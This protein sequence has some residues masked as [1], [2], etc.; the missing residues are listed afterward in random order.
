[1]ALIFVAM[2]VP[3]GAV[4]GIN[5]TYT[6]ANPIAQLDQIVVDGATYLGSITVTGSTIVLGDAP[7]VSIYIWYF[8]EPTNP[9]PTPPTPIGTPYSVFSLKNDLVGVLHG[10]TLNQ[11]K[12]LTQLINRAA[13]TLVT[14]FDPMET[15]RTVQIDNALYDQVYDYTCPGDLKGDRI[16]DIFP[17]VNRLFCD[18]FF[19]TYNQPFDLAKAYLCNAS[20]G[21]ATVVFNNSVKFLRLAKNF[22][23]PLQVNALS[24]PTTNGTW[25]GS[26][27]VVNLRTDNLNYVAAGSSLEFDLQAG[28]NPSVAFIQNSTMTPVDLTNI[29]DQGVFFVWVWLPIGSSVNNFMLQWGSSPIDYYTN[30]TSVAQNA[31]SFQNG[32]NLLRFEWLGSIATGVP[33]PAAIDYVKLGIN[34]DGSNMP[35]T[36][37]NN[38]VGQLGT[39]YNIEYYSKFLFR[40]AI[41]NGYLETVTDDS[42]LINLDTDSYNVFFNLVAYYCGQQIQGAN[43]Q[44]DVTF[45]KNEYETS[46][47]RYVDKIK[48]ETMRPRQPYYKIAGPRSPYTGIHYSS[49]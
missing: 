41:T 29:K 28:G 22:I 23:A 46:K 15:K 18:R 4:N 38:L 30:T 8:V 35:N 39:I 43:S 20:G 16:I 27:L 26:P 7:T 31:L 5:M 6:A 33:N 1:M 14:D 40:D 17:Q 47:N 11:V 36:R 32:W 45:W 21:L 48:S 12:N 49:S 37:A 9:N 44:F 42:N 25:T 13:R 34:W 2:E 19:Q 24:G 3:A 10:T